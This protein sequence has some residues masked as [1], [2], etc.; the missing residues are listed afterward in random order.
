MV[1]D[2]KRPRAD[3]RHGKKPRLLFRSL[4]L[5]PN[6]V[7]QAEEGNPI[8]TAS[9]GPSVTFRERERAGCQRRRPVP[10]PGC[11]ARIVLHKPWL[12]VFEVKD[13]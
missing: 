12:P 7:S 8:A 9:L 11:Q 2:E 1:H 4:C 6:D 10:L 13:G 3:V 5:A